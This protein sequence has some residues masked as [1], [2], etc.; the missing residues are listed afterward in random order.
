VKAFDS[1]TTSLSLSVVALR[2]FSIDYTMRSTIA[3][4]LSKH[5]TRKPHM[6][7]SMRTSSLLPSHWD[8]SEAKDHTHGYANRAYQDEEDYYSS[9]ESTL[10]RVLEMTQ[11]GKEQS[12][13]WEAVVRSAY[14]AESYYSEEQSTTKDHLGE[15]ASQAGGEPA[16]VDA[17]SK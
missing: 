13:H 10:D 5:V 14:T 4:T 7:V 17:N 11:L 8:H 9:F 1:A 12:V 16:A 15:G 3:K 2:Y 6:A